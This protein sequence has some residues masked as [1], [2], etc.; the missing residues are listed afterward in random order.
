MPLFLASVITFLASAVALS[1][2]FRQTRCLLP[3][4]YTMIHAYTKTKSRVAVPVYA[5]HVVGCL[6]VPNATSFLFTKNKQNK[7]PWDLYVGASQGVHLFIND[8][9]MP[10]LTPVA[11]V[12]FHTFRLAVFPS[13]VS[14]SNPKPDASLVIVPALYVVEPQSRE[15]SQTP[16]IVGTSVLALGVIV[17]MA[18]GVAF[19]RISSK[20]S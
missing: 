15:L 17:F 20:Q 3:Q 4:H 19:S 13:N 7:G 18:V 2:E 10:L 1:P 12:A 16:K 11:E 6:L 9:E 8:V 5:A 14:F